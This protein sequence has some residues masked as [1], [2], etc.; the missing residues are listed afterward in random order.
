MH[1]KLQ[2]TCSKSI[3]INHEITYDVVKKSSG[4]GGGG[5]RCK[6]TPKSFDLLKIL[7]TTLIIRVKIVPNVAWIQKTAPKVCRKTYE[8]LFWRSHQK[9]SWWSLWIKFV[10]KSCTKPFSGKFGKF[11]QKSFANPKMCQLLNLWWKGTSA[12][13]APLLKGQRDECPRHVSIFRRPCA[14]YLH[15]L[16]LLVVGWDLSL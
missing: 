12:A 10:E 5:W 13:V 8:D 6:R 11:G 4:V 7:A 14:Y 15:A 2:W 9:R 16:S 1:E 3:L